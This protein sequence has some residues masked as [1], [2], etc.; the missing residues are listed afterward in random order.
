MSDTQRSGAPPTPV[1][2]AASAG[3][4]ALAW[5]HTARFL[6]TASR[7]DQLPPHELPEI[8]FVGRSNAGKSTAINT[9]T[10]QRQLAFA[11]KTPGRTQHINLFEL[12]PKSAADTVFADLPGYGYAAVERAAK[13]RWQEVMAEYLAVRRSLSGVVLL[14]DPRHGLKDLDRQLLQFVAPRVTT[15][16]VKLLVVLTKADKLNRKEGNEALREAQAALAEFVTDESDIGVTLF[17][18]LKKT[19]L[20]DVATTLYDWSHPQATSDGAA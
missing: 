10:Q 1:S 17:S 5:A 16:Q 6:T 13:L 8:A 15:G 12:G 18:A 4:T 11:S 7:L 20:E 14:V 9:L 19:G 3:K 2:P